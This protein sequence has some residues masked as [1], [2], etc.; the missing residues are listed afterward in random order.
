MVHLSPR[1]LVPTNLKPSTSQII[2][3]AD[4]EYVK[5]TKTQH[6]TS[7]TNHIHEAL[8]CHNTR[9]ITKTSCYIGKHPLMTLTNYFWPLNFMSIFHSS[10][11]TFIR[12]KNCLIHK[13]ASN[14]IN[15][16]HTRSY[17]SGT[18][19]N[20]HEIIKTLR[21]IKKHPLLILTNY[22]LPSTLMSVF[23]SST[24][25]FAQGKNGPCFC[26]LVAERHIH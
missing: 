16:P 17:I 20:T 6:G 11:L 23:H 21:N 1:K 13:R 18:I 2:G 4:E 9:K 22:I 14:F 7:L 19:V 8:I 25:M 15:K 24:L 26:L 12:R 10:I 5:L 3:V